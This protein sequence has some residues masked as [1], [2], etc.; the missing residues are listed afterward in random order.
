MM[1]YSE[2][3][4]QTFDK[5]LLQK[6]FSSAA[7]TYNS[8]AIVQQEMARKLVALAKCKIPTTL[9]NTLE[10]GCGTGLLTCEIVKHY[11]I[12]NYMANDLV[13]EVEPAIKEIISAKKNT[14][15]QFLHG[16]AQ[17]L[18]IT[19]KQDVIWSGATIQWIR[20]LDQFFEQTSSLLKPG[21][22]FALSSFSTNNF[23]EIKTL[24]GKGI[25]Y[26]SLKDV[27]VKASKH[28]KIINQQSWYNKLWFNTPLEVLKHMRHT[29]VN[30]ISSTKW[31]KKD[32]ENFS[33]GYQQYLEE[34]GFPLTYHPFILI[35]K[36]I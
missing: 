4:K 8:H 7:K 31:T 6:R 28:F 3:T 25:E 11:S 9:D 33:M 18:S 22:Y 5:T 21:G 10:I 26:L 20:D 12:Y 24:T 2:P 13:Q 23:I 19:N 35:L 32:L 16:D 36:K 1:I 17:Q 27:V 34:K 30:G 29:G 15:Y 14:T